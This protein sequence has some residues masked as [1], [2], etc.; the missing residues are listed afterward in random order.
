MHILLAMIQ[1]NPNR[2][3][4]DI[5]NVYLDEKIHISEKAELS[6][7]TCRHIITYVDKE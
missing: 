4:K 7:N 6:L 2:S 5:D 1:A 3:F